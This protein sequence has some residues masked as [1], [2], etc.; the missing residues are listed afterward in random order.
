MFGHS[1]RKCDRRLKSSTY[2]FAPPQNS[3][4]QRKVIKPDPLS[5]RGLIVGLGAL[6]AAPAIARPTSLMRL[7]G[8]RYYLHQ[9]SCPILPDILRM[10]ESGM[11]VEEFC[12]PYFGPNGGIYRGTWTYF[13]KHNSV[14]LDEVIAFD[15][16][17]L[18]SVRRRI[19]ATS[20][21]RGT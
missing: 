1:G 2:G 15:R 10:P 16:V 3:A 13:G 12:A 9:H 5:R 11:T 7:A 17:E 6:L 14:W 4:S 21:G 8:E 19:D 20:A 18:P